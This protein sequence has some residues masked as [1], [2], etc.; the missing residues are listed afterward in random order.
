[1]NT[2]LRPKLKNN[3]MNS[4]QQ[5]AF[6]L[7]LSG[8]NLLITSAA[9]CGKS[10]VLKEIYNALKSRQTTGLTST[11]GVSALQIKG[12]TLH[13]YLGIGLGSGTISALE[14]KIR[15]SA[16]MRE[17]WNR[18]KT[19][20]IDE[21]S[22]LKPDLLTKLEGLA[23]RLR[24]SELPFGGIQLIFSG[25]FLQLPPVGERTF[26]FDCEAWNFCIPKEN[27][28][29]LT[30]MMRQNEPDFVAVLQKLRKANV[31]DECKR[32]LGDRAKPYES[33]ED[34]VEPTFLFAVNRKVDEFNR[35]KYNAINAEEHTY[36][37][38][39]CW[40]KKVDYPD[41]YLKKINLPEKV[42]LK[43]GAQVMHLVNHP[44]GEIVNGSLGIVVDFVAAPP[45]PDKNG[46]KTAPK[47]AITEKFPLV[48]F[49]CGRELIIQ[50]VSHSIEEKEKF[51][52]TYTQLPLNLA[53]ASTIHKTQ[54]ATIDKVLVDLDDIFENGQMYVA[55]SRCKTLGGLFIKNL[56]WSR[57]KAHPR[58]VKF[59]QELE[60]AQS[61]LES[62]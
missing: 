28:V 47:A 5:R 48:K 32:I 49:D 53:W 16:P 55:L 10:F 46:V 26:C 3:N 54:G 38:T 18:L 14:K 8:R 30:E 62:K 45:E 41:S 29:V 7:A 58:A 27:I 24:M 59:Y 39:T 34:G 25:D 43:K 11:T 1:M 2:N 36:E 50:P 52:L 57:I 31:D 51:I 21:V 56:N 23:R 61:A 33:E 37:M 35:A 44:D 13:S 4:Q 15:S 12:I 17:R 9:G 40:H 22:M 6:D 60:A 20:I 19:L 42:Q